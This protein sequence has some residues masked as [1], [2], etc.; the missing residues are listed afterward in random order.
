[1]GFTFSSIL[2]KHFKQHI[3]LQGRQPVSNH[4]S[5]IYQPI[6]ISLS[7]MHYAQFTSMLLAG[8]GAHPSWLYGSIFFP[9]H[10]FVLKMIALPLPFSTRAKFAIGPVKG[11]DYSN[12]QVVWNEHRPINLFVKAVTDRGFSQRPTH[13]S[14]KSSRK[15]H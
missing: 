12:C 6:T 14:A 7:F 5:N 1:M 11:S 2:H 8:L 9:F 15:L 4:N 13:Y 10:G 3:R